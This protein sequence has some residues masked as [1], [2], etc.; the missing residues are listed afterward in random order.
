MIILDNILR[1]KLIFSDY[2]KAMKILNEFDLIEKIEKA[3]ENSDYS[4][5]PMECDHYD[6]DDLEERVN[7][8]QDKLDKIEDIIG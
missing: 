3:I 4:S 6:Y 1:E 7:K 2:E 8:L 5:E